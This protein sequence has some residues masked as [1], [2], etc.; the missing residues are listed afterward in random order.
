MPATLMQHD[1]DPREALL[2]KIGD[3]S[4]IEIFQ[5]KVLVAIYQRPKVTAGGIHLTDDAL[6]ED[7]HQGKVALVVAV[8]PQAF[9]PDPDGRWTFP[10]VKVGDWVFFRVSDGWNTSIHRVPCRMLDDTQVRGRTQH[11]DQVW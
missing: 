6:D 3:L 7:L 10:D 5:N 8:G 4:D 2:A 11:P 1:T 9:K